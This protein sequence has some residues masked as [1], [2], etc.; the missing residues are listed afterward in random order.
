MEFTVYP[1][2]NLRRDSRSRRSTRLVRG[3]LVAAGLAAAAAAAI[4]PTAANAADGATWDAL[5]Q[6]E[7][8]GNWSINTGNGYYGG[9]QFSLGTWQANGGSGNPA[10]ASREEQIRVAENVLASQGWG[11]WP[12]CSAQIGATGS[13]EPSEQSAAPVETTEPSADDTTTAQPAEAAPSTSETP[14]ETSEPAAPAYT[15]PDVEASDE[16]YTVEAGDTLFEIS[17]KLGVDSGWLGI[18]AV[19]QDTIADPDYIEV[20]EALVLPAE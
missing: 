19:N 10:D 9:L 4:V 17:E 3:G 2:Q 11:A 5:A 12:T 15:L 1:K 14:A 20:G 18:Y 8:G 7:S 16:T 13:A 6:C